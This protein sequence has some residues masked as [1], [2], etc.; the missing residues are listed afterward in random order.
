M[1]LPSSTLPIFETSRVDIT[2]AL[3]SAWKYGCRFQ[4]F[5][6]NHEGRLRFQ[7]PHGRVQVQP[8]LYANVH[9]I[10][11]R[12]GSI[13]FTR[14]HWQD[15]SGLHVTSF[16]RF[17]QGCVD[18]LNDLYPNALVSDQR[19]PRH[20]SRYT[21]EARHRYPHGLHHFVAH[22]V[23]VAVVVCVELQIS[24]ARPWVAFGMVVRRRCSNCFVR[25]RRGPFLLQRVV[26]SR[27]DTGLSGT[28]RP[29]RP[30]P[31]AGFCSMQP[32]R[33]NDPLQVICGRQV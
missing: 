3:A 8:T 31:S 13:V 19:N 14:F 6:E 29:N 7:R 11:P 21:Q 20:L 26:V 5:P 10:V 15:Q 22:R 12:R 28:S 16:P 18:T 25:V 17:M 2:S 1:S 24:D 9:A 30:R 4:R 23:L 27:D 33:G 32:I